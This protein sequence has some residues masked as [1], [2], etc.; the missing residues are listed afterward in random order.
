MLVQETG[1][2]GLSGV[3]WLNF[4]GDDLARLCFDKDMP[5]TPKTQDEVQ[6]GAHLDIRV[7][8]GAGITELLASKNEALLVRRQACNVP[9][10]PLG[11]ILTSH[12][13][14]ALAQLSLT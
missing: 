4:Q 7:S 1:R 11:N 13:V 2:G 8:Q 5:A 14:K 10:Q 9:N 12:Q 3:E 6:R